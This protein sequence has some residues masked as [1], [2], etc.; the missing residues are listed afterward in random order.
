MKTKLFKLM[1]GAGLILAVMSC[2]NNTNIIP[3]NNISSQYMDITG[4]SGLEIDAT[5][6]AEVSFTD[7]EEPIEIIANENLHPFV[8]VEKVSDVL[9]VRLK[10]NLNIS[11]PATLK[12]IL[13]TSAISNF[14][15]GGA[16]VIS[17]MDTLSA[18]MVHISL[19]GASKMNGSLAIQS[20][21]ADLNDASSLDL[22]GTTVNFELK[23]SGGSNASGYTFACDYLDARL[24]DASE[25]RF[26]I[27]EEIEI[28]GSGASTLFYR[29]DAVITSQSLTGASSVVKTD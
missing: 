23:A 16:S 4:Y 26:T 1:L 14:R 27:L 21:I 7:S 2:E 9:K 15:A 22:D 6:L 8:I 11:G 19:Y 20:L 29:G 18:N 24:F 5:F 13:K 17:L 10:D 12:V 28:I 3:S 25:A